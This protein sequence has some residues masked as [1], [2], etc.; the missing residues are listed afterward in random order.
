MFGRREEKRGRE[1]GE[2]KRK[3]TDEDLPCS[4]SRYLPSVTGKS[5]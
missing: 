2:E 1:A 5:S 4:A 3:T